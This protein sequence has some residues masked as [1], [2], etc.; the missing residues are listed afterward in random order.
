MQS[1]AHID[2]SFFA[3]PNGKKNV[4]FLFLLSYT[5]IEFILIC[6][7]FFYS[8]PNRESLSF[9]PTRKI[10]V[11]KCLTHRA[12]VCEWWVWQLCCKCVYAISLYW[13]TW[14]TPLTTPLG[15][16][17]IRSCLFLVFIVRCVQWRFERIWAFGYVHRINAH[18]VYHSIGLLLIQWE[19]MLES[20]VKDRTF[21]L[22][23]V[24]RSFLFSHLHTIELL[25][26]MDRFSSSLIT[27]MC[28][29]LS[30]WLVN[31][32]SSS[33]LDSLCCE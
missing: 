5:K 23:V 15:E 30:G 6:N 16:M 25:H 3:P 2:S 18:T 12:I 7:F 24:F 4:F 20:N 9:Y 14:R 8:R 27:S 10:S 19:N 17:R 32:F 22:M 11:L 1:I 26:W 13:N 29:K 31:R 33:S 21:R 28:L